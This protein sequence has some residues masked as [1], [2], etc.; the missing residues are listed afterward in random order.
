MMHIKPVWGVAATAATVAGL[1]L[2]MPASVAAAPSCAAV[3]TDP[4]TSTYSLTGDCQ[5]TGTWVVDD[6]WTVDGNNH[7]ITLGAGFSGPAIRSESGPV[8]GAP[9]ELTVEH[10]TIQAA[11]ASAGILFDGAKGAV[12]DVVINGGAGNDYGVEIANTNG[13]V[14][15]T[16]LPPDQ[17]KVDKDTTIG[18]YQKAGIYVHGD[19]RF[20]VLRVAISSPLAV[21]S[22][23]VA[24]IL[25]T[26]GAHGSIKE[27]QIS[28]S[29]AVPATASAFGAG[30]RIVKDSSSLPRRVEVKRNVLIGTNADIG[31]SVENPSQAA[32]LTAAVDCNLIRRSDSRTSGDTYGVGVAAWDGP[33]TNVVLTNS[34]FKGNWKHATGDI[35]GTTVTAGPPNDI[36]TVDSTCPPGAP[37]HVRAHRGNHKIKV[38]WHAASAPSWAPLT[39]Y[40]VKAKAAGHRAVTKKV[41]PKATKAVLKGLKNNRRY[42][43][44]V[45]ARSN[46]GQAS[47]T[48]RVR[49]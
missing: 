32:K 18:G 30:V 39:E 15:A 48:D 40:L 14:F 2:P 1:L 4:T 24:G 17:V 36:R 27:S 20:S 16:T 21:S 26:E 46:G 25:A 49:L 45:T 22:Q 44:T 38:T 37:T 23:G 8:G 19:I 42:V 6:G 9:A 34:T 33:K 41:G 5:L 3:N 29:D 43:V 12:H 10:V 11:G 31:I 28:L 13:V 35:S 47:G 7:T